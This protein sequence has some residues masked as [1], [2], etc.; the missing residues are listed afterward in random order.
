[1][2]WKKKGEKD[3]KPVKVSAA[4]SRLVGDEWGKLPRTSDHWPQYLAVMRPRPEDGDVHDVRIFDM[5]DANQKKVS[6][7]NY[8]SL[9]KHEELILLAGWYNQKT[10]K[11]EIKRNAA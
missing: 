4:M 8:A 10:K 6:V 9:D 11:G 3:G 2:F 5:G 1:M 7:E